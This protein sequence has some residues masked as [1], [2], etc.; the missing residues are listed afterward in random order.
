MSGDGVCLNRGDRRTNDRL[1]S[2]VSLPLSPLFLLLCLS[3]SLSTVSPSLSLF[4]SPLFLSL[5]P[6]FL[7]LLRSLLCSLSPLTFPQWCSGNCAT[8]LPP[9]ARPSLEVSSSRFRS[10]CLALLVPKW[11]QPLCKG[12]EVTGP[13][14]FSCINTSSPLNCACKSLLDPNF[15]VGLML[16]L[17]S[18][19][20]SF[21]LQF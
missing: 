6:L 18:A 7:S 4:L 14:S 11:L 9:S 16:M 10:T 5:S 2:S 17:R 8:P 12:V 21:F 13:L 20:A 3:P 15:P 19:R 1:S